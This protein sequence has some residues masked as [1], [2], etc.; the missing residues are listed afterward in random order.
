VIVSNDLDFP[1]GGCR[2][3]HTIPD[4]MTLS[5]Y[6]F[7]ALGSYAVVSA[8]RFFL[9]MILRVGPLVESAL[10]AS[11]KSLQ[12]H[13]DSDRLHPTATRLPGWAC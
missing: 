11:R 3:S 6:T 9:G 13:V 4:T 8:V 5:K 10:A 2:S 1:S 7:T 12:A